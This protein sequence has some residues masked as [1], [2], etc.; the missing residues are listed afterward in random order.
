MGLN[1][2]TNM[3][4]QQT[5]AQ[6][7]RCSRKFVAKLPKQLPKDQRDLDLHVQSLTFAFTKTHRATGTSLFNTILPRKTP[8]KVMSERINEPA[9]EMTFDK[10]PKNMQQR[11]LQRE[12]ANITAMV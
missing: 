12:Q 6:A 4:Y 10:K 2:L 9:T 8:L 7:G 5:D 3:G 1:T 11:H